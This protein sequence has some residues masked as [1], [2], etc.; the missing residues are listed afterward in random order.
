MEDEPDDD[1][2]TV[3]ESIPELVACKP[4]DDES[5]VADSIPDLVAR[6]DSDSDSDSDD[7]LACGDKPSTSF[8]FD[9]ESDGDSL[10]PRGP[11]KHWDTGSTATTDLLSLC[12]RTTGSLVSTGDFSSSSN[13]AWKFVDL[14]DDATTDSCLS[15][16]AV[17]A[18]VQYLVSALSGLSRLYPR[19]CTRNPPSPLPLGR[20]LRQYSKPLLERRLFEMTMLPSLLLFGTCGS[21]ATNPWRIARKPF[22]DSELSVDTCSFVLFTTIAWRLWQRSLVRVG[23]LCHVGGWG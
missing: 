2:S 14:P 8:S 19:L 16:D 18:R 17:S 9:N 10:M 12:S 13:G 6:Y 20:L 4:Y 1:E 22:L 15:F 11:N 23:P 5:T 21:A 7:E 3:A